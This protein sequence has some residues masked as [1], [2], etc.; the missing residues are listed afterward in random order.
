[1]YAPPMGGLDNLLS[2]DIVTARLAQNE[3]LRFTFAA[4]PVGGCAVSGSRPQP[5]SPANGSVALM[6]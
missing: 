6:R 4:K 3:F 2:V 5:W 1:M